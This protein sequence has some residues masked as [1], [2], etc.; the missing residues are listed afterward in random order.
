[1]SRPGDPGRTQHS[2]TGGTE[3]LVMAVDLVRQIPGAK[4]FEIRY[5][6]LNR[7]LA[8]DEEPTAEDRVRWEAVAVISRKHGKHCIDTTYIGSAIVEPGDSHDRGQALAAVDLLEQLGAN[9]VVIDLTD[10]AD[11]REAA[12]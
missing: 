5:D 3:A 7:K 9:A 12:Q 1:M 2:A 6:A 4:T 8:K 11:P 10:D